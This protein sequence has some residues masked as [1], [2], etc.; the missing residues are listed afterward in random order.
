MTR[1][2]IKLKN[3]RPDILESVLLKLEEA[4]AHINTG[5]DWI[6]LDMKDNRPRA[7]ISVPRPIL[8]FQP[9]CKRR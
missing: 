7:L 5:T 9:T 2:K 1:G 4:G 6:S 3:T 8:L